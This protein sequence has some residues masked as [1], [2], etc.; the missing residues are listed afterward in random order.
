M[1]FVSRIK[2]IITVL[3]ANKSSL[4]TTCV[5]KNKFLAKLVMDNS[6]ENYLKIIRISVR[7]FIRNV[8]NVLTENL[9][10]S[11]KKT[12]L[13]SMKYLNI[14]TNVKDVPDL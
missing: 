3:N 14:V 6:K 13:V 12:I 11:T 1:K 4:I 10:T 9:T 2:I 5:Q 7:V 8:A